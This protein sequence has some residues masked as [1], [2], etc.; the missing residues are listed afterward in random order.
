VLTVALDRKPTDEARVQIERLVEQLG[1]CVDAIVGRGEW[2]QRRVAIAEGLLEPEFRSLPMLAGHC[3]LVAGIAQR[4]AQALKMSDDFVETVRIGALVHDVGL[5]LLDYDKIAGSASI[6]SEQ[7]QIVTEHPLVGAVLVEPLLGRDIADVVLRHHERFD[8][9]GYPGRLA[10]E[11]IP[12]A[13]RIVQIADCWAAMTSPD[14][15]LTN[16]DRD[17]A[18]RRLRQ[19]AGA[20]FDPS[21]VG[22]FLASI[23]EIV[24]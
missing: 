23:D 17:E 2:L 12:L 9:K 6:T 10:G 7:M 21:L 18:M 15:Y 8:G 14:S 4:F 16:V 1:A 24:P 22:A 19:E 20:Q 11:R 3:R 13:A 5:R